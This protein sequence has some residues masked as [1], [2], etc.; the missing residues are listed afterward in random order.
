VSV[1]RV[2]VVSGTADRRLAAACAVAA[3]AGFVLLMPHTPGR[4]DSAEFTLTLAFGGVA[5]PTGYPLYV[6]L[7]HP[8]VRLIHGL[9]V[10]WVVAAASWSAVGAAVAI[11]LYVALA[12]RVARVAGASGV[13]AAVSAVTPALLLA[14]NPVWLAAAT[15]AEVYSWAFAW[16]AGAALFTVSS[17]DALEAKGREAG[18]GRGAFAWGVLCGLGCAHHVSAV[19][20]IAPFTVALWAALRRAGG[21]RPGLIVPAAL[22]A[23]VPL[24]SWL[25]LYDRAL[26]PAIYQW[27]IDPSIAGVWRH[28]TAAA[29]RGYVGG[30]APDARNRAL[31]LQSIA[32]LLVP[33][34]VLGALWALRSPGRVLR[35]TL[36]AFLGGGTVLVGVVM[37]YGVPDPATYFVPALMAA[38]L[39]AQPIVAALARRVGLGWALALVG[40]TFVAGATVAVRERHEAR[41]ELTAIDDLLHRAW[42]S[43]PFDRGIVLWTDDYCNRLLVF[44]LLEKDRPD[45]VAAN[46]NRLTWPA[47]RL[48]FAR[49]T[50]IDPLA[51]L[52]T[53]AV[54]D[55]ARIPDNIRRQSA[56]PVIAF[57]PLIERARRHP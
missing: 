54:V 32:P 3:L 31:I 29:Y 25:F 55:P 43:V 44:Q 13:P 17:L 21:W 14:L 2:S 50:G 49:R 5:H 11:G 39:V 30:F 10:S 23:A 28:V 22:G 34:L 18:V 40:A 15:E 48:A 36:L 9:G 42:H 45:L 20:F 33:G 24:A 19:F 41:V 51:G 35:W 4:G 1:P 38:L 6:L 53:A 8:F 46:P 57:P 56:V 52:D 16:L 27:P 7:G 26:H 37:Y 47:G 12:T